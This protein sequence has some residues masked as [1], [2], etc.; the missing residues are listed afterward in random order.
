MIKPLPSRFLNEHTAAWAAA[1]AVH[2]VLAVGLI[3]TATAA[4][5][6]PQVIRVTMVAP[7]TV[8]QEQVKKE[9]KEEAPLLAATPA[10]EPKKAQKKAKKEPPSEKKIKQAAAP[11][12]QTSGMQSPDAV[13]KHSARTQP[14]FNAVYLNNP[15]PIYPTRARREGVQGKVLLEVAVTPEGQAR[16]VAIRRSS[17]SSLLDDAAKDAVGRWSFVPAKQGNQAVEANVIVP[18]EFKLN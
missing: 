16:T 13:E 14:V 4:D 9:V 15:A 11:T 3:S 12:L 8:V 5:M 7:S 1:T 6:P 17:G 18:V 2:V 10:P